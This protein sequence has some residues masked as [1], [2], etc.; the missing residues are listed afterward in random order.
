MSVFDFFFLR[1]T[2]VTSTINSL[3]DFSFNL[4]LHYFAFGT[5]KSLFVL[6]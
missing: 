6:F 2:P 1:N 3:I 4:T 5:V